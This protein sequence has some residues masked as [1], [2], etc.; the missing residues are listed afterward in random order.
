MMITHTLPLMPTITWP[1]RLLGSLVILWP[2]E[3]LFAAGADA[4]V[5]DTAHGHS[6]GASKIKEF[7]PT[8]LSRHWLLV[9]L[10]WQKARV[11]YLS[12]C[13]SSKVDWPWFN[14]Y[15]PDCRWC[16]GATINS[17]LWFSVAREYGKA[18]IAD[19]GSSIPV[20]SLR[21][22]LLVATP[23]CLGVCYRTA[24]A[25]VRLSLLWP[26]I[27][28][29]SGHGFRWGDVTSSWFVWPVLPRRRNEANKLVPEGVEGRVPSKAAL[30]ILSS[31]C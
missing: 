8:S 5:I 17:G 14:L 15:D 22:S 23:W 25:P 21:P 1:L 27:Q 3:A 2:A 12:W 30:M 4:I 28:V 20:I 29:L 18:I 31:K 10:R 9:T 13:Y 26:S 19:G 6:A 11:L 7:G 16:R 24:E